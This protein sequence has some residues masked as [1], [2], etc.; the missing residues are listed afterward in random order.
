MY[1]F[2]CWFHSDDSETPHSIAANMSSNNP[3]A[4]KTK[5]VG[6]QQSIKGSQFIPGWGLLWY[7][8][9]VLSK[10]MWATKEWPQRHHGKWVTLLAYNQHH[11]MILKGV[12]PLKNSYLRSSKF[13]FLLFTTIAESLRYAIRTFQTAQILCLFP[14]VLASRCSHI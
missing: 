4:S 13:W 6:L 12:S 5:Y 14:Y 9:I 10:P 2:T 3:L 8:A 7:S 11:I 1:L